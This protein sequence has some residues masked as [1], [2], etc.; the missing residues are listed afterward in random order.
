MY[1]V[2][3]NYR[4]KDIDEGEGIITAYVS[5][6][7]NVDSDGDMVMP[8]AF[9]K[10]IAERGPNSSKPRIKHLHQHST[11]DIIGVPIE[12]T[13]DATGLLVKSKFGSDTFSQD[14]FKQH[15]DGL[16]TEFSIG[17]QIITIEKVLDENENVDYY[18]LIELK[19]WEFSSVTWG[20][21]ALTYTTDIKSLDKTLEDIN[22]RMDKLTKALKQGEYTDET[23]E[24]FEIEL[25]QI[26][27]IYN[28]LIKRDEPPQGTLHEPSD[29]TLAGELKS[30]SQK[31]EL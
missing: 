17:Y 8:G 26:Q 7:G 10:T 14:K 21:N 6:F 23:C 12:M 28:E 30:L 24:Q 11:W 27:T 31:F 5:I 3:S 13:E 4:L 25:K 15:V 22:D 1:S 18:K 9:T 29:D 16:L 20:A 2:K 19:L